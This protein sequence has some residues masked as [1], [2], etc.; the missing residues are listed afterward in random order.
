MAETYLNVIPMEKAL[1]KGVFPYS[2]FVSQETLDEEVF[3][4]QSAF[5][6]SLKEEE[7]SNEEYAFAQEVW[8]DLARYKKIAVKQDP[9][10]WRFFLN[11]KKFHKYVHH[12]YFR[13]EM[14]KW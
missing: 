8:E 9:D 1:R 11:L 2:H 13:M 12:I 10:K 5:F 4:S 3:P 6:N 14:L 7:I